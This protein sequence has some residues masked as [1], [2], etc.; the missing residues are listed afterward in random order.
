MAII[1]KFTRTLPAPT[2]TISGGFVF[3]LSAGWFTQANTGAAGS[4]IDGGTNSIANGGGDMQIF[5]DTSTTT[6]LPIEVV[7]FVTGG[8]P[9]CQ[10]WVRTPS[11]TAGDTIT[12]GKD[13]T[14]TTQPAVG[15]AFGRNATWVDF[16]YNFHLDSINKL[17]D[18]TGNY[19]LTESGTVS[20]IT[21]KIGEGVT[22]SG[23][24]SNYLSVTGYKGVVG[25]G[26][27]THKLWAKSSSTGAMVDYG[28]SGTGTRYTVRLASGAFRT[29]VQGSFSLTTGNFGDGLWH[30]F[31]S[32]E[33]GT[34]SF[35]ACHTSIVDGAVQA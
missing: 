13:D 18:S 15:A 8:S 25:S 1:A 19:S 6:Q 3:L 26:A 10:V 23:S 21:G 24:T 27:R 16:E 28:V 7:T 12:I 14:Q 34:T 29:E 11:Y 9:Q 2:A 31:T 5:S 33:D 4:P 32:K 35:P 17:I 30:Q 22:S 20:N